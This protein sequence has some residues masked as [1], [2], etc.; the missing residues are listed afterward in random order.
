MLVFLVH[1][2]LTQLINNNLFTVV[3]D[4]TACQSVVS[5]IQSPC[6]SVNEKS[7]CVY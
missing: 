5:V 3:F 1:I 2:K 6:Q 4:E 7:L